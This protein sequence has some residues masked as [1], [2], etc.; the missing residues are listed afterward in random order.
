MGSPMMPSPTKP[1]LSGTMHVSNYHGAQV[2]RRPAGQGVLCKREAISFALQAQMVQLAA[3][4][5]ADQAFGDG[6]IR[7]V[8]RHRA[9]GG[10]RVELGD[11][12]ANEVVALL[13]GE[14]PAYVHRLVLEGHPVLSH[15]LSSLLSRPALRIPVS[16]GGVK[17]PA[18]E[19][20]DAPW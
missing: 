9:R 15:L 17:R 6:G 20:G 16:R 13:P 19:P 1:I 10:E 4:G 14:L 18:R 8:D 12:P 11:L 5:Q 3:L 7:P 2:P